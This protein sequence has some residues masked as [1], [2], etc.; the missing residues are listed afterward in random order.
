[1][2]LGVRRHW[3]RIALCGR[4]L[5]AARALRR[6]LAARSE[7]AGVLGRLSVRSW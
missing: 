4:T 7:M 2:S 3:N 6:A 1:V 5:P